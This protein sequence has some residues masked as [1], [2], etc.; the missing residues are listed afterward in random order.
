MTEGKNKNWKKY[1]LIFWA[2]FALAIASIALMFILIANGSLGFMP[3]FEEL[4]NPPNILSSEIYTEDGNVLDKYFIHE[5]RAFVNFSNLPPHLI[6]A[7]VAT[8]D[9]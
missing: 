4:E 8:E 6:D 9:V 3:T 2:L 5:N 1:I 7:L